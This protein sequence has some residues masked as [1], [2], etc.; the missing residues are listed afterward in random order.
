[1][2]RAR[3]VKATADEAAAY[4][5]TI[6]A[7]CYPLSHWVWIHG[8]RC[9]VERLPKRDEY[10]PQYEIMIPTGFIVEH[11]WQHTLLCD[12]MTDLKERATC[13]TIGRCACTDCTK[14]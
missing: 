8:V 12:D 9:A 6:P 4:A 10:D 7:P 14:A 5:A 2:K 1:M 11:Y 3:V 13:A